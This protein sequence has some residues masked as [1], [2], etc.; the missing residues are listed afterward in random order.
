MTRA[1]ATSNCRVMR[2]NFGFKSFDSALKP[3]IHLPILHFE[4]PH[5]SKE[6]SYGCI[7]FIFNGPDVS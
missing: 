6:D 4:G 1:Q 5:T 3:V 2:A 7:S